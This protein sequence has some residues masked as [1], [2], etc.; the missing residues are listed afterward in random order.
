MKLFLVLVLSSLAFNAFALNCDCE[1]IVFSPNTGS[2]QMSPNYLKK[3]EL[4]DF[5][6]YSRKSQNDCRSQC[7]EKYEK[8]MPT[9]RIEALL[10]KYSE[11][12]IEEGALGYN[13]TGLTTLKYPVRVKARLGKLGL[14]NVSDN[15][16]VIN[17]EVPCF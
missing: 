4:D 12:L 6:N 11:N 15:M 7:L 1:V 16:H 2:L 8:D 5:S 3:Y 9:E 10:M 14:G 13:C 17:Y